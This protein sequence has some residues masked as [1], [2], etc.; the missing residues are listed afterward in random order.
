MPILGTDKSLSPR[1]VRGTRGQ[2]GSSG[3]GDGSGGEGSDAGAAILPDRDKPG[4]PHRRPQVAGVGAG[5]T[6]VPRR[7]TDPDVD[8]G[9]QGQCETSSVR[10]CPTAERIGLCLWVL[11]STAAVFPIRDGG[12][13]LGMP[14]WARVALTVPSIL[15]LRYI[16]WRSKDTR[17]GSRNAGERYLVGGGGGKLLSPPLPQRALRVLR[18]P[19]GGE[20]PRVPRDPVVESLLPPRVTP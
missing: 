4:P 12:P 1:G 11:T 3:S 2:N 18:D 5:D 10:A 19:R 15:A 16:F 20:P 9:F 14:A 8:R 7:I 6:P 13:Q 17:S